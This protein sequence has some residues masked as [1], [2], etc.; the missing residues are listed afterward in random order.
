VH[1]AKTVVVLYLTKISTSSVAVDPDCIYFL[2]ESTKTDRLNLF[3]PSDLF[4]DS[5]EGASCSNATTCGHCFLASQAVK[6]EPQIH[7]GWGF[8]MFSQQ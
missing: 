1:T 2:G 5:L 3:L 7:R 6:A 4:Q 8:H